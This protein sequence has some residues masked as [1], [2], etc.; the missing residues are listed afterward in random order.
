MTLP[1]VKGSETSEAAAKS[2][3]S[4]AATDREKVFAFLVSMG[5][6]GATDEELQESI[7]MNPSSERP[8]RVELVKQGH[9]GD[10][11]K[12]RPTTSGRSATVWI[13]T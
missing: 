6:H 1:F 2:M 8:R 9:V 12:R 13:A 11:G 5:D 7:P 10:S 3:K 4:K